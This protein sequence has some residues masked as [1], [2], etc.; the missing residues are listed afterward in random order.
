L[1]CKFILFILFILVIFV[2]LIILFLAQIQDTRLS[3]RRGI[4]R[5]T[6]N[7]GLLPS[8]PADML[9]TVPLRV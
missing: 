2:I 5:R 3:L 4:S 1:V 8:S 7:G 6:P 9:H